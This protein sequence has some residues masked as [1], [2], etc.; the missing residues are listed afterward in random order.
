[1]KVRLFL[2]VLAVLS[3]ITYSC[4]TCAQ[5]QTSGNF[6]YPTGSINFRISKR[7]LATNC[8]G[9]GE[10]ITRDGDPKYHVGADIVPTDRD[11]VVGSPVYAISD[12]IVVY[13]SD[14]KTSGWGAGNIGLVIKHKLSN[15]IEFLAVYGHIVSSLD[16]GDSVIAGKPFATIGSYSSP[17]LHFGI[18]LFTEP[19]IDIA[20]G[21][22][23]GIMSCS[24]WPDRNGFQN[25]IAWIETQKSFSTVPPLDQQ[26]KQEINAKRI[27][28]TKQ[29]P[30][31]IAKDSRVYHHDR[32]CSNITTTD[33][34]MEFSSPQKAEASGGILCEHCDPS[35][36]KE[37]ILENRDVNPVDVAIDKPR[38]P[39]IKKEIQPKSQE[40]QEEISAQVKERVQSFSI[41][42]MKTGMKAQQVHELYPQC[43]ENIPYGS[44]CRS[45]PMG[46]G[47]GLSIYCIE[48]GAY[49]K[50]P[51][52]YKIEWAKYFQNY[53]P[54]NDILMKLEKTYGKWSDIH[55][56][57]DKYRNNDDVYCVIWGAKYLKNIKEDKKL[58][59]VFKMKVLLDK[60]D[61]QIIKKGKLYLLAIV[62]SNTIRKT[63]H[64]TLRLCNGNIYEDALAAEEIKIK[65]QEDLDN[66]EFR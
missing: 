64:L 44:G 48:P 62:R 60:G 61:G 63:C 10:Y 34:L 41:K 5:G 29:S 54:P 28:P 56:F 26:A 8:D 4:S 43:F 16:I 40:Q 55:R 59:G 20:A 33:G 22:G 35:V 57:S 50:E 53:K 17:H 13:R 45:A 23:W 24:N 6:Y 9:S 47:S 58:H 65:Q 11:Q 15:A 18:Q 39:D 32:N 38:Q 42:G 66:L 25:P 19:D 31:Y 2:T 12:G 49:T 36:V 3:F 51:I 21:K 14:K 30:V 52:V 27:T 37:K 1:M 46:D 7:W